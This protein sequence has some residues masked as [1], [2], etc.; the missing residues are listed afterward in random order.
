MHDYN[1]ILEQNKALVSEKQVSISKIKN[2]EQ[3]NQKL[4]KTINELKRNLE[5][6]T[7]AR[8]GVENKLQSATEALYLKTQLIEEALHTT[9]ERTETSELDGPQQQLNDHSGEIQCSL[10]NLR[11]QYEND[12]VLSRH[13]IE[14]LYRKKIDNYEMNI[15][16]N[17][18]LIHKLNENINELETK[19]AVLSHRLVDLEKNL[20]E[21]R[22]C[23]KNDKERYDDEIASLRSELD[24][25][26]KEYEDLMDSKIV[27][28]IELAAYR[29]ML[30]AEESRLNM[31]TDAEEG[32]TSGKRKKVT[33]RDD[34]YNEL[35]DFNI[36]STS[37]GPIEIIDICKDGSYVKL[38][39][40]NEGVSF[41][42]VLILRVD[43]LI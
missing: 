43:S 5:A 18:L 38:L 13:K 27:L 30:E 14:N 35:Q 42:L 10:E 24:I 39:N 12:V 3:E 15:Q 34:E 4:N 37:N 21:E 16:K 41:F 1:D 36:S 17:S 33:L 6:E 28:D 2:I 11:E 22:A 23:Y 31:S 25:Q 40:K 7:M 32:Y 9:Y 19:N 26:L 8:V 29:K 20:A